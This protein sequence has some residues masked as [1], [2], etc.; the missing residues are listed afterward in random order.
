MGIKNLNRYFLEKCS[1]KSI[2]KISLHGLRG[3]KV[4]I[5]ISIYLYKFLGEDALMEQMY[6]LVSIF[7]HYQIQPIFVF[8]G[9]TPPE[10]RALVH[11]RR[12]DKKAATNKYAEIC[13]GT[14]PAISKTEMRELERKMLRITWEDIDNVRNLLD[15][16]GV[17]FVRAPGEADHMCAQLVKSGEAWATMTED[18]DLF[19]YGCPRVLRGLNMQTREIVLYDTELIM[20][21]LQLSYQQFLTIMVIFGTDYNEGAIDFMNTA[22]IEN[23]VDD[24]FEYIDDSEKNTVHFYQ[25]LID[26]NKLKI[27]VEICKTACEIFQRECKLVKG[28]DTNHVCDFSDIPPKTSENENIVYNKMSA[29]PVNWYKINKILKPYGFV[30]LT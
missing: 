5:D 6:L 17:V 21:E 4:A 10:K 18:M 26:K 7:L 28:T 3:K 20:S 25:W 29:T 22:M 1:E 14:Q 11:R 24:Y 23:V 27:S 30:F 16:Y 2:R 15:A 12:L 19:L 9:K 13:E 8:D